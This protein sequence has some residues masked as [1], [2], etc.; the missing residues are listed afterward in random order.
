MSSKKA[1]TPNNQSN[2]QINSE[3]LTELINFHSKKEIAS[4]HMPGH[5]QRHVESNLG[6]S[7]LSTDVL[8][9]DFTE[10]PGFD[11][12]ANPKGVLAKLEAKASRI[13]DC[14]QSFLSVNGSSAGIMAALMESVHRGKK[15]LLPRNCHRS[16]INGLI[17]TGLEPI[18]YEPNWHSD[19]GFWGAVEAG[20]IKE[21]LS[22]NP[23]DIGSVLVVSPTYAGELSDIASIAELCHQHGI[24]L[25][26]DAAHGSHLLPGSKMLPSA[27]SQNA[28]VIIHSLHKTLAALTQTAVI[29]INNNSIVD[30]NCLRAALNILHTSSPSYVLLNS[31]EEA[32]SMLEDENGLKNINKIMDLKDLLID[33][34]SCFA[35]VF[36]GNV[37]PAHILVN[38]NNI[39]ASNIYTQLCEQGIFAETIQGKGL[40][41]L[42]GIGSTKKDIEV[43]TKALEKI[44]EE[45]SINKGDF[46]KSFTNTRKDA[47]TRSKQDINPREAFF[48]PSEIV[49]KEKAIGRIASDCIA[50]CPP[51][52][53]LTI[54]G[55]KITEE[56][57][58]HDSIKDLRVIIG[59]S[60]PGEK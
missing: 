9:K 18:W 60:N 28:D 50:P 32:L 56:V 42:L 52:T 31:I 29:H 21:A 53:A 16:A 13:W 22:Q 34:I 2:T 44:N 5:K 51:G 7:L 35:N 10:L 3:T 26:I 6:I 57:I 24:A 58:R 30:S 49:P 39:S 47:P 43:L 38:F 15:V 48:M 23:Q 45:A 36:D 11:E 55:Q 37:D 4:F 19:W 12:L 25:I 54:P 20:K 40:L 41:F 59:F 27:V 14:D 33:K 8:Q 17:L 46:E 1:L